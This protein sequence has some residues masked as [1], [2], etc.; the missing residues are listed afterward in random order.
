MSETERNAEISR[1]RP[2]ARR[3][4]VI[5]WSLLGFCVLGGLLTVLLRD[6]GL[7]DLD[8]GMTALLAVA[9]VVSGVAGVPQLIRSAHYEARLRELLSQ[10]VLEEVHSEIFEMEPSGPGE[11]LDEEEIR[12]SG[13]LYGYSWNRFS[14]DGFIKGRYKS[15][16]FVCAGIRA[17]DVQ[18]YMDGGEEKERRKTVFSGLWM[19]CAL[20]H[21]A[22]EL[23]LRENPKKAFSAAYQEKGGDIETED[24]DFNARY[25]IRTNDPRGARALLTPQMIGTIR[26]VNDS[27]QGRL[28][29]AIHQNRVHIAIS[30]NR[31]LTD[32]DRDLEALR[33]RHRTQIKNLTDLIDALIL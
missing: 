21:S 4:G 23:R 26:R 30:N 19:I 12:G 2:L 11:A 1:L 20:P 9:L 6:T 32:A 3:H 28:F 17:D 5:G 27:A 14:C 15:L 31:N 8:G 22:A 25:E 18:P 33:E 13:L 24:K 16:A 29:L 7:V 10:N